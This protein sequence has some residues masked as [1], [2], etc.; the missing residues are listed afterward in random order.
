MSKE[1]TQKQAWLE[2]ARRFREDKPPTGIC[3]EIGTLNYNHFI[4]EDIYTSMTNNLSYY[5]DLYFGWSDGEYLFPIR[6]YDSEQYPSIEDSI[7][8]KFDEK[9]AKICDGLA[10]YC[11]C[12]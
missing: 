1:L 6:G 11:D 8:T 9:R 4:A 5:L 2:T 7:Q 3:R 12:W 10:R